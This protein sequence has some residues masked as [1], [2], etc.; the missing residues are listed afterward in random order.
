MAFRNI[1][2]LHSTLNLILFNFKFQN[3][4]LNHAVLS[5]DIEIIKLLISDKRTDDTLSC[6]FI[7]DYLT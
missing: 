7:Y 4:S 1:F 3:T 2:Q 6:I 5:E